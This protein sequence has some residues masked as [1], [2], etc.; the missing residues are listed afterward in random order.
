VSVLFLL[1]GFAGGGGGGGG[2]GATWETMQTRHT[3]I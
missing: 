1:W 2:G 3:F